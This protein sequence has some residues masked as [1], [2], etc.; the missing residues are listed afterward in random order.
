MNCLKNCSCKAAFFAYDLNACFLLSEVFSLINNEGRDEIFLTVQKSPTAQYHIPPPT[1]SPQKKSGQVTIP[2]PTNS[3]QKKSG[4]V[5]IILGSSFGAFF[6]VFFVVASCIFL[7]K[8][9]QE[10]EDFDEFFVD[11]V[12]GM[13]TRFSYEELRAMT[14]NFNH[15]LGE[16][17]FGSLF[18]RTLSDG[19]NVAMKRLNGFGQ[20]KKSF[21]PEVETIGNIHHVNW[22]LC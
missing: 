3:P 2:P 20:V 9:K 14:N 8:K 16:G 5:T 6:G 13:P 17:G 18:Q 10:F 4:Q 15:M 1:N 7:F 21:L 11:Q 19:T 12:P 22:I